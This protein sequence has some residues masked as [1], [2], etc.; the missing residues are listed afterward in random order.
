MGTSYDK[1]VALT[2][3]TSEFRALKERAA[4]R[5]ATIR[6]G[7]M[8]AQCNYSGEPKLTLEL[9]AGE[10]AET[11]KMPAEERPDFRVWSIKPLLYNEEEAEALV[12]A[13]FGVVRP[14]YKKK[15]VV[16]TYF[17]TEKK[18]VEELFPK[19]SNAIAGFLKEEVIE[20]ATLRLT[21]E[22][23]AAISS[24]EASAC[25]QAARDDLI[26]LKIKTVL[27]HFKDARPDVLRRAM[28]EYVTHA[29]MED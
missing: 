9:L 7:G 16:P 6:I 27:L 12:K 15:M 29:I 11:L 3:E 8:S 5:L 28:D 24:E 21:K 23:M 19:M 22:C 13:T 4:R 26:V 1:V 2:M 10:G 14:G 20:E 25:R 17:C 18:V